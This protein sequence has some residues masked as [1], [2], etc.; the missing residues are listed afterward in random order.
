MKISDVQLDTLKEIINIGVGKSASSLNRIVNKRISLQVPTVDIVEY[1]Q[2]KYK[3]A[4]HVNT[5]LSV[6]KMSFSGDLTGLCELVF[7]TEGATNIVHILTDDH[8]SE[9]IMDDQFKIN[10]LSE[11]GNMILNA[12]VGTI[13]NLLKTR[14]RYSLP[15]YFECTPENITDNI[16][17]NS[18][19]VI[20][21]ETLFGIIDEDITG[22]FILFLEVESFENLLNMLTEYLNN[23][24]MKTSV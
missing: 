15:K 20:Y 9:S 17:T 2:V 24:G 23:L 4:R 1:N 19:W 14:L 11:I 10:T 8:V 7:P 18:K 5:D 12:L 21:A 22:S 16:S 13:G 6:I 3:L